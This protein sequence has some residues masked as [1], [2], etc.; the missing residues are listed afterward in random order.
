MIHFFGDSFTY[1]QGCNQGEEYY[2]RTYDGTQKTWVELFSKY[3]GDEFK[4]YA[5]PGISNQQIIDIV[6]E[7]LKSINEGDVVILSRTHDSRFIIPSV[8]TPNINQHHNV[9]I[10]MFEEKVTQYGEMNQEYYD[11]VKSYIEKVFV[12]NLDAVT[13][14][15]DSIFKHL[16]YYFESRNIKC[17]RWNVDDHTLTEDGRA[18]YSIISDEYNDINDSHWSWKGHKEFF[19]YIKK[20]ENN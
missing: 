4:N 6:I 11:G 5:R 18:K 1:C 7:K 9:T 15:Y 14:R 19:Q 12:P 16:K 10:S 13:F 20:Y 17:I 8:D 2:D 3:V